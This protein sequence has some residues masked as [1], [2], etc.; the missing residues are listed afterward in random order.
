MDENF[1][2]DGYYISKDQMQLLVNNIETMEYM[3]AFFKQ[4]INLILESGKSL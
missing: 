4:N 1:E 3:L 2:N